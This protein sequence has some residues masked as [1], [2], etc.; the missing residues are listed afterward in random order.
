MSLETF[1]SLLD[2]LVIFN[3]ASTVLAVVYAIIK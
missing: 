2:L 1:G 3:T